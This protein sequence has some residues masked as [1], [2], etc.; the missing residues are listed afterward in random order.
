L[1]PYAVDKTF[2][3][4]DPV[5]LVPYEANMIDVAL[6]TEKQVRLFVLNAG[7]FQHGGCIF[8]YLLHILELFVLNSFI[9]KGDLVE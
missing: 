1:Q 6:L 9:F 7:Y 8:I 5:T 3:Q 4:F 2:L